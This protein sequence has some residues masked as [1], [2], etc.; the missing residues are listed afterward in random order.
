ME[1]A[2]V[3]KFVKRSG[4]IF[5]S[6]LAQFYSGRTMV[7]IVNSLGETQRLTFTQREAQTRCRLD[8]VPESTVPMDRQ[9]RRWELKDLMQTIG[10]IPPLAQ[11][12][13][14]RGWLEF[15]RL[16]METYRLSTIGKILRP[17]DMAMFAQQQ[18]GGANAQAGATQGAAGIAGILAQMTGAGSGEA[19]SSAGQ[20]E[21]RMQGA[22][23]AAPT[24]GHIGGQAGRI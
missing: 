8:V 19:G 9:F 13:G 15:L 5:V 1:Q 12:L 24:P 10:G 21:P 23:S 16:L 14:E 18:Q 11:M 17:P 22:L 6:H 7:E 3:L 4:E 2:A 20:V